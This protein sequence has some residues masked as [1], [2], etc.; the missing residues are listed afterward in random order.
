MTFTLEAALVTRRFMQERRGQYKGN[1]VT[2]QCAPRSTKEE[3]IARDMAIVEI[4]FWRAAPVV[5]SAVWSARN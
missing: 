4:N 5:N 2:G 1:Y 3:L